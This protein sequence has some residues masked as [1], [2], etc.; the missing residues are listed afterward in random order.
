MTIK[1]TPDQ[2][3]VFD[4]LLDFASNH[5][6]HAIALL[7]GFAGTGKTTV[8]G[9]VLRALPIGL[10]V[11][12]TA[13]TNKAVSVLESKVTLPGNVQ[14]GSIHSFLGMRLKENEDGTHQCTQS[15]TPT[16]HDYDLAIIDECSMIPEK[17]FA[18]ILSTKRS[19]KIIFV[20][21][22]AQLPPVEDKGLDSPVFRFVNYKFRLN[23]VVRQARGNPIIAASIAVRECINDSR[24]MGLSELMRAFP[25]TRP[26]AAGIMP[27]GFDA[28]VRTLITEH[29]NNRDCRAVA[30]R[31]DTVIGINSR[32]HY[33]LYRDP[34]P[35]C[36]GETLIAQTEFQSAANYDG[37]IQSKRIRNSEELTVITVDLCTHPECDIN[38]PTARVMLER[39]DGS[40]VLAYIA[41]NEA[42]LQRAIS[43]RFAKYNA[44][45]KEHGAHSIKAKAAS[46]YAWR[47]RR[48]Y[49]PL[50]HTYA[51]TAHKSQ[52]STF[53][54]VLVHWD[55]LMRQRSDFEF[56][57]MLYV[58]MTRAS[59]YLALVIA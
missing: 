49:A 23:E 21:D 2:Q 6:G 25:D 4:K 43:E 28:I 37:D 39:D 5:T 54:T 46:S 7:E 51:I 50:R 9:E 24:R 31:N 8:I 41:T 17:L 26:C 16:L 10:R 27:G 36:S 30:W 52:G 22:P 53:D 48:E 47:L 57:R 32:V 14:F 33:L 15:G 19:C 29:E 35:F 12:I 45:C 42:M 55:D 38:I 1:L 18:L 40:D 13:S 20:G 44:M 3:Q 59:K 34:M 56:N 58:A 11:A